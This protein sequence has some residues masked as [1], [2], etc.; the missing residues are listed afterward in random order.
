MKKFKYPSV[1]ER[2]NGDFSRVNPAV[3]N[4]AYP[5]GVNEYII[6]PSNCELEL[7]VSGFLYEVRWNGLGNTL[8]NNVDALS[9][10]GIF[11]LETPETDVIMF[12]MGG[13]YDK[14]VHWIPLYRDILKWQCSDIDEPKNKNKRKA[15]KDVV[16]HAFIEKGGIDQ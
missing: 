16:E 1:N 5:H 10:I 15:K 13:G 3:F 14:N 9:E 4:L 6:H 11:L 8:K 2:F 12:T 7:Y